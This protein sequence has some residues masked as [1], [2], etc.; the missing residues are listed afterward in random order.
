MCL[1]CYRYSCLVASNCLFPWVPGDIHFWEWFLRDFSLNESTAVY[2]HHCFLLLKWPR[3]IITGSNHDTLT[4][5]PGYGNQ[6]SRG[7][8]AV[9]HSSQIGCWSMSNI[10]HFSFKFLGLSPFPTKGQRQ[11]K[12]LIPSSPALTSGTEAFKV[13]AE[14]LKTTNLT[15]LRQHSGKWLKSCIKSR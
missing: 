12:A 13:L 7:E 10:D 2:K 8:Y 9:L 14:A 5:L 6:S 1:L 11:Q 4:R 15:N 3:S